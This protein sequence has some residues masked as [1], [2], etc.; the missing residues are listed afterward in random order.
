MI[1]FWR[2]LL[3]FFAV[4]AAV[5]GLVLLLSAGYYERVI[6]DTRAK[7]LL[8]DRQAGRINTVFIGSSRTFTSIDPA[9]FDSLTGHRT[10]SFN[11]GVS[12]FFIPHTFR[13]AEVLM[14]RRDL[15][16]HYLGVELSLPRFDTSIDPFRWEAWEQP[17]FYLPYLFNAPPDTAGSHSRRAEQYLNTYL[18]TLLSPALR[19]RMAVAAHTDDAAR[20]QQFEA[21][22]TGSPDGYLPDNHGLDAGTGLGR[23]SAELPAYHSRSLLVYSRSGNEAVN[24][25]YR[26]EIDRLIGLAQRHRVRLFFYLPNRMTPEEARALIPLFRS[27]DAQ[28][29]LH[30]P[31]D[32]RFDALFLPR[33]SMDR[34]HV[35]YG[36]SQIYTG[37]MAEAFVKQMVP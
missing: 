30:L 15:A 4:L 2:N 14:A 24:P 3:L 34:G 13:T 23:D 20:R 16:L 25:E 37:L 18:F 9:R 28:H 7:T 36:G 10:C 22:L 1:R 26:E 31:H 35:N 6:H 32:P 33:F 5:K 27:I 12:S 21:D 29:R 11:F 8:L 17:R 19:L